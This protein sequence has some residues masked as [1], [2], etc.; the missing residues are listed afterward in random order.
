MTSH[1]RT[2]TTTKTPRREAVTK[3]SHHRNVLCR[4]HD[5]SPLST[6]TPRGGAYSWKDTD[7]E[8]HVILSERAPSP[9]HVTPIERTQSP[10]HVTL[11]E[12]VPPSESKG[13]R[14]ERS[15]HSREAR[16]LTCGNGAIGAMGTDARHATWFA[17]HNV[18]ARHRAR[19][20]SMSWVVL[21]NPARA[22]CL[23]ARGR[24]CSPGRAGL[25]IVPASAFR[26]PPHPAQCHAGQPSREMVPVRPSLSRGR[27]PACHRRGRSPSI[28][29]LATAPMVRSWVAGGGPEGRCSGTPKNH[30]P[31]RQPLCPAP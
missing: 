25:D 9:K 15:G 28:I 21:M 18:G 12:R 16:F 23:R 8:Q 11:S 2:V 27:P 3:P 24:H 6:A 31:L 19:A 4:P 1:R 7:I 17:A 10:Q 22:N 30:V 20:T 14:K 26:H 29:N 13:L 5:M